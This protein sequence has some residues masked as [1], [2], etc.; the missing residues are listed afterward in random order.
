MAREILRLLWVRR[1]HKLS[2]LGQILEYQ[3][4]ILTHHARTRMMTQN[5]TRP[6]AVEHAQSNTLHRPP[7]MDSLDISGLQP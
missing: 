5:P 4:A 6:Q 7:F 2:A 3:E 1:A